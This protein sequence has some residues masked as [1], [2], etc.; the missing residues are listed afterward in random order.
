MDIACHATLELS[1]K[2]FFFPGSSK[3]IVKLKITE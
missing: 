3:A 2:Q 1:G